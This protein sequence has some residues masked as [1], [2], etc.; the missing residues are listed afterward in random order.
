[1]SLH[2]R[3]RFFRCAVVCA[4]AILIVACTNESPGT[5][6]IAASAA[7]SP[8][9][10]ASDAPNTAVEP[11]SPCRLLTDAEVRAVFPGAK[12]GQPERSR[13]EY[14]IKACQWS[15]DSGRFLAEVWKAKNSTADNEIR[16]LAEGFV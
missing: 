12:A 15:P 16:G 1:M 6:A 10:T 13:E 4:V 8:Q 7:A 2:L 14:G 5:A 11:D 9:V 3:R